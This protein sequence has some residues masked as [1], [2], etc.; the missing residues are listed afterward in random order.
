MKK[1]FLS[2]SAIA[3]SMLTL[4]VAFGAFTP[5][6][7]AAGHPNVVSALGVAQVQGQ[8]V[9]VEVTILVPDGQDGQ[10]AAEAALAAQGARPLASAGLES[11]AYTLTGLKWDMLPVVQ[12]YNPSGEPQ[13]VDGQ[14]AL[15]GTHAMW[16]GVASSSFD[17]D[18]G[19]LTDRCPSLVDECAGPQQFDG[20]ND[21]TFLALKGPCNF[22][23]G[24]TIGVTW[25][26][27][28]IDEADM[29]LTTKVTWNDGCVD[30]ANSIDVQTVLGHENGHV[31]GLGHSTDPA[32]LMFT[33]YGG[34]QCSLAQDD[35]DATTALY[36]AAGP[37]NTPPPTN[38]PAA[39]TDT[40]VAPTDTPIPTATATPDGAL[41]TPTATP[42]EGGGG[43]PSCPPGQQRK[44]AC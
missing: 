33:P 40:P 34:A 29:A 27:T 11:E 25:Y 12:N 30:V 44:N 4:A 14:A 8:E 5:Q 2:L 20:F 6:G 9:I 18:F 24:C 42:E 10:A 7:E 37:T 1:W 31:V 28:S 23:F 41:P 17:I 43:P 26:S 36:G 22:V 13:G 15:E 3:A 39:P 38:T 32:S 35:I 21:V 16:D 19:G